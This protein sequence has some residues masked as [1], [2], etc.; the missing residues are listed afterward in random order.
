MHVSVYLFTLA[1]NKED[2]RSNVRCWLDD[3]CEREFYDYAGL[4]DRN[5][6]K[7]LSAIPREEF[8]SALDDTMRF[9]PIIENDIRQYKE[10]GSMGMEGYAHKRYGEILMESLTADMPY[11]NMEYWDWEVPKGVP[12]EAG[13]GVEWWAVM[14]DFHY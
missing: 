2:A 8:D 4:D 7:P 14:A 13:E 10:S 1:E 9:L 6:A 3:Y 5:I 12:K 11:F